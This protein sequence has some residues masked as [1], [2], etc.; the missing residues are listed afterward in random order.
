MQLLGV[1]IPMPSAAALLGAA[2]GAVWFGCALVARKVLMRRVGSADTGGFPRWRATIGYTTQA[3][4]L[5]AVF[6]LALGLA[7]SSDHPLGRMAAWS[8]AEFHGVRHWTT[9][10]FASIFG[11]LMLFDLALLQ[12]ETMILLHH[13]LCLGGLLCAIVCAPSMYPYFIAGVMMLEVGSGACNYY[14]CDR[15]RLRSHLYGWG[16]SLSNIGA[17]YCSCCW[18]FSAS[19]DGPAAWLGWLSFVL[20][21][22]LVYMRQKEAMALTWAAHPHAA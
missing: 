11:G 20:I 1:E 19:A 4:V 15:S 7:G 2:A 6:M 8:E 22:G 10:A 12:P 17:L 13:I 3:V 18:S 9:Y 21:A 14:W 5:P 16:M